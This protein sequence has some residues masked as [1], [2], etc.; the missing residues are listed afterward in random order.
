MIR[1]RS[2]LSK[3][4]AFSCKYKVK[5]GKS[6]R[7]EQGYYLVEALVCIL[8]VGI[9]SAGLFDS[10]A[11]I[12]SMNV[13][14]QTHLQAVAMGQECIDQLRSIPFNNIA[15]ANGTYNV[16]VV[17]TAPTGVVAPNGTNLFP[18]PLLRDTSLKYY[19]GAN[20]IAGVAA[21][22]SQNFLKVVNNTVTV[23]I[24]DGGVAGS[25]DISVT[26]VW[27]D[28]KGTHTYTASSTLTASGING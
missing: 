14:S 13:A 7:T 1:R 10:Y 16:P 15:G 6:A 12:R 18:R 3:N 11:K 26:I 21:D 19:G 20:Q 28:G 2:A 4:A 17:G 5:A 9:L 22:D 8:I 24:A 27:N 25:K 23:V